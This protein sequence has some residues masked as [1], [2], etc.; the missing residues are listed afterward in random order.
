[1]IGLLFRAPPN[2]IE[3]LKELKQ[4]AANNEEIDDFL[5]YIQVTNVSVRYI[6]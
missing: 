6:Q 4:R 5:D 2:L 1:M 3:G